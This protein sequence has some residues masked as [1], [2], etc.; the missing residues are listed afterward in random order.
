MAKRSDFYT[1][2][3]FKT[4]SRYRMD[5]LNGLL[6]KE[7]AEQH[8]WTLKGKLGDNAV[9]QQ[10]LREP[11]KAE[12]EE[13]V[14]EEDRAKHEAMA[15]EIE[16]ALLL[17]KQQEDESYEAFRERIHEKM[18]TLA[19]FYQAE[20]REGIKIDINFVNQENTDLEDGDIDIRILIAPN[21]TEEELSISLDRANFELPVKVD[22]E[23]MA[24]YTD[25]MFY[26][27]ITS[28]TGEAE[29]MK[30]SHQFRAKT[31]KDKDKTN[32]YEEFANKWEAGEIRKPSASESSRARHAEGQPEPIAELIL[33]T[34]GTYAGNL[35][36][37]I[38]E[39][40]TIIA[41]MKKLF[42]DEVLKPKGITL[43][44]IKK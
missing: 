5:E 39:L 28:I 19:Q 7:E 14:N 43:D 26:A 15:Q 2:D 25:G 31:L 30:I 16:K 24:K 12:N 21:K 1:K 8:T 10:V 3:S 27:K 23:I 36:N 33:A 34:V 29:N 37:D 18:S 11:S 4:A 13:Q 20:L 42:Q 17:M 9:T 6:L 41:E 38:K 44:Q 22:D 35:R 32:S 40:K